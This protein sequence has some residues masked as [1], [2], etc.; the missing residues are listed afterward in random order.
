MMIAGAVSI[1]GSRELGRSC[2]LACNRKRFCTKNNRWRDYRQLV[3]EGIAVPL[4]TQAE[5]SEWLLS[6]EEVLQISLIQQAYK[7][8]YSGLS[9]R[10]WLAHWSPRLMR[11]AG[12]KPA[13]LTQLL[14]RCYKNLF[15]LSRLV[16]KIQKYVNLKPPAL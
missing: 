9:I 3:R 13:F 2:G 15:L 6:W 16:Q 7:L 5:S 8:N 11:A 12:Q 14:I 1:R 4:T 10:G